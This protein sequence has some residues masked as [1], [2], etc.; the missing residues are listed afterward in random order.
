MALSN[1]DIDQLLN[2]EKMK[3]EYLTLKEAIE[4]M[5]QGEKV[6]SIFWE[7]DY[8]IWVDGANIVDR[9]GKNREDIP[10]HSVWQIYKEPPKLVKTKLYAYFSS[11]GT[12]VWSAEEDG[13]KCDRLPDLDCEAM[14]QEGIK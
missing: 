8:F 12:T 14:L 11:K 9:Y 2:G 4:A 1:D 5:F 6:R 3:T 10:T 13:F 7:A